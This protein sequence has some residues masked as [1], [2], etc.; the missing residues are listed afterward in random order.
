MSKGLKFTATAY[1]V[2]FDKKAWLSKLHSDMVEQTKEGAKLWLKT[3]LYNIPVW[4]EASHAT[5]TE[6]AKAVGFPIALGNS[7]S[8]YGSRRALG[9]STGSGGLKINKSKGNYFFFYETSL[10]YLVWNE[11]HRAVKGDGSGIFYKLRNPTPY[12][13]QKAGQAEFE[14]FAA[15]VRLVNPLKYISGKKI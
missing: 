3:V 4:S 6:L 9:R 10:A 1:L 11:Y 2:K 13:F 14:S 7:I 8:P 5:F 15:N 12:H